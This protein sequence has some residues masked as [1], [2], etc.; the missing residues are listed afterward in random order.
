[1]SDP[2]PRNLVQAPTDDLDVLPEPASEVTD[3][4]LTDEPIVAGE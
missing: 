4:E 1:M 3:E 2:M